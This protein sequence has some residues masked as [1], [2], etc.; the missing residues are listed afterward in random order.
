MVFNHYREVVTPE[1]AERYWNISPAK[2]AENVVPMTA[3]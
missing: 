2:E 1:E 3:S